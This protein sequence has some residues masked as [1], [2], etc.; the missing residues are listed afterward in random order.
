MFISSNISIKII[1]LFT[2]IITTSQAEDHDDITKFNIKLSELDGTCRLEKRLNETMVKIEQ[3]LDRLEQMLNRIVLRIFR[4]DTRTRNHEP[5][6]G[7]NN[8]W[9]ETF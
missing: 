2:L 5:Y 3:H 6:S 9:Q 1:L 4:N 8:G 7:G